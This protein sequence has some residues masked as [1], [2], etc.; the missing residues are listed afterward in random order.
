[1]AGIFISFEGPDGV[2][3][4]TQLK[5]L[6]DY[7][8]GQGQVVRCT[9][10]PGG[11][12]IGDKIRSLL[13]DPA[14]SE[15]G[16]RTEALLYMA[17]RAQ[18]VTEFIAPALAQGEI[19]LTDRY[20]DSTFVYQGVA[21]KLTTAELV[22]I[23]DFATDGIEPDLTILLDA[24]VRMLSN[25]RSR[26]GVQDR[27]ERETML[28]HEAVRRGFLELA[29]TKPD[30]IR[31]ISAADNIEVIHKAIVAVIE[32]FLHWRVKREG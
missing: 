4:T 13:L 8:R 18:H 22:S 27:I 28:F 1:M 10:E 32:E 11:T 9:R 3:K 12:A 17:A 14:N 5:L 16:A 29:A 23:N 25:R 2:G 24:E 6:A 31:V 19:V 21:R 7:L 15:M 30:R 20:A 26:R